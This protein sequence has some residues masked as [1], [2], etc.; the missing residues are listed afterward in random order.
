VESEV[1]KGTL[2]RV[3][4]P[5]ATGKIRERASARPL[6]EHA[7][8]VRVLIVDDEVSIGRALQRSLDPHHDVVVLTSGKE[9]LARIASG[10]RFD[11]IL[12]DL[13]MPEVTGMEIYEEL[14]RTA[15]DQAKRMIFITGGAFTERAREFLDRIPNPRIEKPFAVANILAIIAGVPKQ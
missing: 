3:T 10:E 15:P 9:A 5:A 6:N 1:D 8:R 14:C 4:L 11:A 12:S 13:M 2:F 7:P